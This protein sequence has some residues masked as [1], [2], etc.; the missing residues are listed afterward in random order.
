VAP[1]TSLGCPISRRSA[2]S[3]SHAS[4]VAVRAVVSRLFWTLRWVGRCWLVP[5][6]EEELANG[7]WLEVA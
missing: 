6:V 5:E 7:V 3:V 2:R 4:V 1:R